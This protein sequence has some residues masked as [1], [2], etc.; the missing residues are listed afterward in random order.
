MTPEQILASPREPNHVRI[1][2]P[3]FWESK[4]HQLLAERLDHV[5]GLVVNGRIHPPA[6]ARAV[7]RC[8]YTAYRWLLDSKLSPGG[9][10]RLMALAEGRLTKEEL[11]PFIIG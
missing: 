6:L 5:D 1:V 7:G 9:A 4:L 10:R 3:R 11:V 8:R 2:K